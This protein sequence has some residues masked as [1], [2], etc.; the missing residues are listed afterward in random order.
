VHGYTKALFFRY[1]KVHLMFK[2]IHVPNFDNTIFASTA[3]EI[4][5]I[6]FILIVFSML[7]K[8]ELVWRDVFEVKGT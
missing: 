1:D 6:K 8:I 7:F 2:I 3:N 5:L 4:V